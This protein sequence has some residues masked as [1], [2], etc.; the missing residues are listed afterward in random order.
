[1]Q[2]IIWSKD[3]CSFCVRAKQLLSLSGIDYQERNI[4]QGPW[5]KDQL[6]TAIP[7]AR[8]VPQII[9][10]DQLIGGYTDLVKWAEDRN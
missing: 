4:S 2:V 5:T 7:S 8:T 6:L 9:I 10:D 1:M 3:N